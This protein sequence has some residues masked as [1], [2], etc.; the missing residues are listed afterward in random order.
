M[1]DRQLILFDAPWLWFPFSRHLKRMGTPFKEQMESRHNARERRNES[2]NTLKASWKIYWWQIANS[3]DEESILYRWGYIF[4]MAVLRAWIE[5]KSSRTFFDSAQWL[6]WLWNRR[7]L[8]SRAPLCSFVRSLA[9]S[10]TPELMGKWSMFMN[11]PRRC[12]TLW[13]HCA[14]FE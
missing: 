8:Q 14:A 10:L 3:S 11:W 5:Q 6:E 7:L 9:H 12:H 1:R 2:E 4:W 13:T